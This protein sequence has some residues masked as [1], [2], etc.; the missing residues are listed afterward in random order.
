MSLKSII[1]LER[2]KEIERENQVLLGKLVMISRDKKVS[3]HFEDL[4]EANSTPL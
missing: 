4:I 1:F 2:T 3:D